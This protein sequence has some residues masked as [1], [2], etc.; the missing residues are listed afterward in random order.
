[1][2]GTELTR[3]CSACRNWGRFLDGQLD[4]GVCRKPAHLASGE[5]YETSG[6]E[7]CGDFTPILMTVHFATS[8]DARPLKSVDGEE[9]SQ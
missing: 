7:S 3:Q 6:D 8:T 2:S 4:G 1:M 5:H 9:G